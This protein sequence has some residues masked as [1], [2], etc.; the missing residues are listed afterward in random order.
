MNQT[1]E[2]IKLTYQDFLEYCKT[3]H[4]FWNAQMSRS[5]AEQFFHAGATA[6]QDFTKYCE[7]LDPFWNTQI[8]QTF[9]EQF[10]HAGVKALQEKIA[11][12]EG[13]SK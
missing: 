4:P 3:L 2:I 11:K 1:K 9:A 8:S 12:A 7:T 13:K 10:F 5:F 6:G